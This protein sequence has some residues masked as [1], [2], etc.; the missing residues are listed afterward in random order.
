MSDKIGSI[1]TGENQELPEGF[2]SL[3]VT[4]NTVASLLNIGVNSVLIYTIFKLKLQK[5]VSYRFILCLCSSDTCVGIIVQPFL[6]ARLCI[7]D[8]DIL[9]FVRLALIFLGIMF[10][11]TSCVM[12]AVI[13]LDRYLHMRH[14]MYY[15]LH[16]TKRRCSLLIALTVI[17]SF[18]VSLIVS[19]GVINN[20][21]VYVTACWFSLNI[22]LLCL[23]VMFYT[24]AYLSI[25]GRIA[26]ATFRSE[27]TRHNKRIQRPDLEFFKGMVI[28]LIALLVFYVPYAIA[29]MLV[30]FMPSRSSRET[31]L[32]VQYAYYCCLIC[33]YLVSSS[34]GVILIMFDRKLRKYFLRN[35]LRR[36]ENMASSSVVRVATIDIE[37]IP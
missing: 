4:L 33:A 2:I 21:A 36:N 22:A 12:T 35:I 9:P 29:S 7:S 23:V 17:I 5:K 28:I 37:E 19:I 15:T 1:N 6:S 18:I 27:S 10:V 34:N 14:L 13:A 3:I 30:L 16:M 20:L 26:D 25:K 8:P 31:K 32:N 24:R 11:Q